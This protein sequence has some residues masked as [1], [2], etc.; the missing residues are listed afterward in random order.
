MAETPYAHFNGAQ[1]R[2]LRQTV[3]QTAGALSPYA[4]TDRNAQRRYTSYYPPY[5][6]D[7][8]FYLVR[9]PYAVDI[10]KILHSAFYNRCTDKTQ[11]FSFYHND[12]ITRRS[13]HLQLVSRIARTI[14]RALRLNLDLIEAIA[15]GHDMGHTPFG[16]AGEQTLNVISVAETGRFFNHNVH[17][18]RV[19]KDVLRTNLTLQ[20]YDGIICHNGERN[21]EDVYRPGK[22]TNFEEFETVYE[23]CYTQE[24]RGDSLRPGTLEGCVVRFCDILAYVGKDRQDAARAGCARWTPTTR[25]TCW[26]APIWT[27]WTT[28]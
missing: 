2:Y 1:S 19:L 4:C 14:G 6:A 24:G 27:S 12:D 10:D 9:G 21:F 11:V 17:S 3:R 5:S 22:C 8:D 18:V 7:P 28:P 23:E 26:A 13:L 25:T 15:L 16:H 20:T